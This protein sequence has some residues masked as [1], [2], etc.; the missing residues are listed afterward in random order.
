MLTGIPKE[1]VVNHAEIAYCLDKSI[2]KIETAI[3][4]T[5]E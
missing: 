2:A 5:L 4:N 1:V 3:L